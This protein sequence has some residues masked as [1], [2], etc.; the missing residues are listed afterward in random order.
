MINYPHKMINFKKKLTPNAS[1]PQQ[2]LVFQG[3]RLPCRDDPYGGPPFDRAFEFTYT[4]SHTF[5]QIHIRQLNRQGFAVGPGHNFL[6]QK[7]GLWRGGAMFM[8]DNAGRIT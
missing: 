7:D 5:L 4:T 1:K 2:D 3:S 8:T 6:A